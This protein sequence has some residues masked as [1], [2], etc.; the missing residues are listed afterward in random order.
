MTDLEDALGNDGS[1]E[2]FARVILSAS[3]MLPKREA[4][5]RQ[6]GHILIIFGYN[7]NSYSLA[8]MRSLRWVN[9]V[10]PG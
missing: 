9:V 3:R 1:Q 7:S 4:P 5:E 2:E 10:T 6:I 8:W